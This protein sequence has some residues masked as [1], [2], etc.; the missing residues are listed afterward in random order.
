LRRIVCWPVSAVLLILV[1]LATTTPVWAHA[2][3]MESKPKINA[4]VKG[5][6]IPIWLRY[7]VRV[8]GKRSRLQLIGPDGSTIAVDAPKQTAP[9]VIESHVAGLK[10]GE[11]KLQW[12]VL[13]SDGHMSSGEVDFTVN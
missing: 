10:P 13:A 6:D 7:N 8:D 3:L 5:S 4:T 2:V 1:V 12:K 9:D 11:Y